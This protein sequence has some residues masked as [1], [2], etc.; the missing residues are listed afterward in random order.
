MKNATR[1]SVASSSALERGVALLDAKVISLLKMLDGGESGE[2][3]PKTGP[4]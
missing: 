3:L 4:P 2:I 1:H